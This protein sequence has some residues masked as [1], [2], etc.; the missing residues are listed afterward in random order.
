MFF[1]KDKIP[2][3]RPLIRVF[4]VLFGLAIFCA[5]APIAMA[6]NVV[7]KATDTPK[8]LNPQQSAALFK[9][10]ENLRIELVASG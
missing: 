7:E 8:P 5:T 1:T 6:A 10:P 3:I 2:M 9:L 4:P